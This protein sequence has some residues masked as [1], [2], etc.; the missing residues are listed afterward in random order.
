MAPSPFYRAL[1]RLGYLVLPLLRP[2]HPKL[3]RGDRE[4]RAALARWTAWASRNR[5]PERP[6]LWVHAAS[7]GEGLQVEAVLRILR[8]RHRSW[9]VVASF[10][11]PSAEPLR[12]RLPVDHADYLPYDLPDPVATMLDLVRPTALVFAKLDLWPELATQAASRGA[13]VGLVAATVSPVSRRLRWPA[14]LLSR[15][16]YQA[17]AMAGAISDADRSRLSTLGT[18][19]ERIVV[20][21]DPGFDSVVERAAAIAP[22]DPLLAVGRGADTLVAGSTWPA[23]HR[24]LLPAF[25]A[26]RRRH[27]R[28]RLILVPHEP[29]PA[30]VERASSQ[31]RR[32]GL[33]PITRLGDLGPPGALVI[34]DRVGVLATL[35][36]AGAVGYVGG[37][38]GWAG[39]HS[40][41]EPAAL[42]V[43][44]LFGPRWQ[45]SRAAGE[46]LRAGGGAVVESSA[47]LAAQWLR[48]L[49]PGAAESAGASAREVAR[50][51]QGAAE[52]TARMIEELMG[53][54]A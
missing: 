14:R 31:A 12:T 4:R 52:A 20:T 36:A 15:P 6:L 7:M 42:G 28:T 9:Q 5:R 41:L 25:A 34:V 13:A 29:T 2:L 46:L 10:F 19:I 54:A 26:I 24:V 45:S 38:F 1:A 11:S 8:A 50:R 32:F 30:L 3:A 40:V 44:V 51:G 37:G 49:E 43:P 27:P 33:G 16:G 22:D 17:V 23:D 53:G 48:W 18:P 21:G 47:A 35:Y 39:L